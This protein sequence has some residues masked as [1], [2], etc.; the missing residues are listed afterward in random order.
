MEGLCKASFKTT[1]STINTEKEDLFFYRN[2][3]QKTDI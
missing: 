1:L 3:I 2:E